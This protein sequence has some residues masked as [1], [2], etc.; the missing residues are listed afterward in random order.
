MAGSVTDIVGGCDN[1]TVLCE[2][3]FC[4]GTEN[5]GTNS[6]GSTSLLLTPQTISFIGE[7]GKTVY[8]PSIP[9]ALVNGKPDLIT[10]AN[11]GIN[12]G[13]VPTGLG[14]S[15]ATQPAQFAAAIM[16]LILAI[17]GLILLFII[18]ITGY[19]LMFSQGDEEKIK[20][21]REQLTSAI[22]GIAFIIFAI[23]ALSFIGINI[24][25]IPGF[26]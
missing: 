1:N 7:G 15:I 5:A 14:F 12:C 26:K 10:D 6:C 17:A 8:A 11:Q 21:A 25:H 3:S 22:A 20:A 2:Q 16:G 23:A 9:C 18:V 4:V 13:S 19:R 24:I